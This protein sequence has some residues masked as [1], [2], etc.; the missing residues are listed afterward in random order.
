MAVFITIFEICYYEGMRIDHEEYSCEKHE[1]RKE[2]KERMA[3]IINNIMTKDNAIPRIIRN[4]FFLADLDN[5]T[6]TV[7]LRIIE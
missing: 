6:W 3:L 4:D 1:S 2:A 5:I 7:R